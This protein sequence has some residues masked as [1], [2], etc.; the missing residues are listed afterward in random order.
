MRKYRIY[1]DEVG[2]ADLKSS[3]NIE[4]RFLCLT[5]VI[6]DIEHAGNVVHPD[7]E[8]LKSKYFKSH[9]DEPVIMH[10]KEL[11]KRKDAF[12]PL[13]DEKINSE[14]NEEFLSLLNNWEYYVI[15]V[16]IDKFEHLNRY[17]TWRH[18]PYHYCQEVL[19]ERYRLFLDIRK[20][21]GDVMIESRG[22]AEDMRLKKSF[23][24]L[25]EMGT[26]NLKPEQLAQWIT[27]KE[28]KVKPKTAN[29]AGLQLADLIAHPC[30]RYIFREKLGIQD[31]QSTFGDKII[32]V[33][34][35][36]KFFK[37]NGKLFGYGAKTLP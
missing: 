37:Y 15:C 13:K 18:D 34:A 19:L 5:G 27:S 6:I 4:H 16:L 30:R 29:I 8:N 33:I 2:N 9:P 31:S 22:G 32:S 7:L 1:I 25:M 17:S 3:T 24:Q 12:T 35:N 11:V 23:R 21:P 10:R 20:C 28:L 26:S 36:G 14:F